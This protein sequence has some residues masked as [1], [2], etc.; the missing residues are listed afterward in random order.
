M[1]DEWMECISILMQSED[2][3]IQ[4]AVSELSSDP[5]V[6]AVSDVAVIGGDPNI[7]LSDIYS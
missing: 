4:E 2:M 3:T 6:S 5:F 1:A 7:K